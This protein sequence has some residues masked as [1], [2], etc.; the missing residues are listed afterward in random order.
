MQMA[1]S[2]RLSFCHVLGLCQCFE[3]WGL[4]PD[5]QLPLKHRDGGGHG[6]M[7]AHRLL[8]PPRGCQIVG[9]GHA[10]GD[11]RAFQRD[12][13]AALGLRGC[14]LGREGEKGHDW[15]LPDTWAAAASSA[16]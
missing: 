12:N 6:T 9:I 15:V 8:D 3:L 13:G 11:D 1:R 10:M 7:G 4:K 2:A 14:N 16:A 5:T